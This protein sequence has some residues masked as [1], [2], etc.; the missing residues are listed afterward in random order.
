MADALQPSTKMKWFSIYALLVGCLLTGG[1]T[2]SLYLEIWHNSGAELRV[3]CRGEVFQVKTGA[4]ERFRF[5]QP[6][7]PL[8]VEMGGRK[9]RFRATAT[10]DEWFTQGPTSRVL[11]LQLEKDGRLYVL[12]S[13]SKGVK[14]PL[15]SQPA[16][17]PLIAEN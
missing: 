5:W 17:F 16:G 13:G 10:G 7:S 11:K 8:V 9:L 2:R 3:S 6:T 14:M 15:P 4:S 12:P 1:C